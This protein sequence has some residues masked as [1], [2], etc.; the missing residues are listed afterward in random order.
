MKKIAVFPGC[1]DPFTIGHKQVLDLALP[2]FDEIIVAV[3]VNI[4][5]KSMF[6]ESDRVEKIKNLYQGEP[7]VTVESYSTL[8]ADLCKSHNAQYIIRGIRNASDFEYE[9]SIAQ[10]NRDLTGIETIFLITSPEYEHISS[11]M[12]RELMKYG[13]DV[14]KYLP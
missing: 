10:T 6:S 2:L 14:S 5:K 4:D 12:V 11:S 9:K 7:K 3:G 13:A 8:T 1:F